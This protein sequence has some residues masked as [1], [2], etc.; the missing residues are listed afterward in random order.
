MAI[1]SYFR[2]FQSK[3]EFHESLRTV[4]SGTTGINKGYQM[5]G[6]NKKTKKLHFS[7]TKNIIL[8][9]IS[10][11]DFN[12]S[13]HQK[14]LDKLQSSMHSITRFFIHKFLLQ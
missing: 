5:Y 4:I 14:Q 1:T 11:E 9:S 2:T 10:A 8:Y 7:P 13:L 3:V 12:F 6:I